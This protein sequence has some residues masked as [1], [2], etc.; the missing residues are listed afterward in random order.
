M[1]HPDATGSDAPDARRSE[2][3]IELPD[4]TAMGALLA[5]PPDE[6]PIIGS[7]LVIG[8]IWGARTPF[9]EDLAARLAGEGFEAV[10][11]EFFH[12]AGPLPEATY[13]EALARMG[14]LDEDQALADL[15]QA[16][17]QQLAKGHSTS[18]GVIG[19]CLGGTFALDLAAQRDDLAT[20]CFY[21]FPAGS[22]GP[23]DQVAA[24]PLDRASE[25]S[26]PLRG[27]WGSLDQRVGQDNVQRL[28][29]ELD[30]R[31]I[32]FEG[33]VLADLDHGFLPAAFDPSADGHE[34][35]A[36]AWDQALSFLRSAASTS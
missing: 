25:I 7:V 6:A 27:F 5:S 18:M 8:D 30:Q 29:S 1:C 12:R 10:V 21:G 3:T 22:P 26:G 13:D 2:T 20:V 24:S 4:G 34:P 15:G 33:T 35:A 19:C 36:G 28:I 9:Y 32:D 23:K 31:Q 11:P 16:I 17:D 14:R